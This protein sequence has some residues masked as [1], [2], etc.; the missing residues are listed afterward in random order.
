MIMEATNRKLLLTTSLFGA[1]FLV[2]APMAGAQVS[3]AVCNTPEGTSRFVTS[4]IVWA[5][6]ERTEVKIGE[7]GLTDEIAYSEQALIDWMR[8][9]FA[10]GSEDVNVG[11]NDCAGSQLQ[12]QRST[13]STDSGND[14]APLDFSPAPPPAE[15]APPTDNDG[16]PRGND[17]PRGGIEVSLIVGDGSDRL[18]S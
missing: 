3:G 10:G 14:Q 5:D 6:G 7:R 16:G 18:F 13:V 2:F 4:V 15:I 1:A 12:P 11:F 17:S 9:E 8:N